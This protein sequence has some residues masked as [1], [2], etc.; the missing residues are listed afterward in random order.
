[1]LQQEADPTIW[2]PVDDQISPSH[3]LS[4]APL[5]PSFISEYATC[6]SCA[7]IWNRF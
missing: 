5:E 2:P 6:R 4:D 3:G 1:V 7:P